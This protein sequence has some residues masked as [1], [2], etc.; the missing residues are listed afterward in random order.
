[1]PDSNLIIEKG[2]S[3]FIPVHAIHHD[4]RY[5]HDPENFIP[6]RFAPEEVKKRPQFSSLPFGE[7]IN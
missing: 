5:F 1:V 2:T 4:C 7:K 6:E 3:I